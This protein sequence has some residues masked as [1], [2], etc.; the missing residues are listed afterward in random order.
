MK[1]ARELA[2]IVAS[3]KVN[4]DIYNGVSDH[5]LHAQRFTIAEHRFVLATIN[6]LNP[7][8]M[9]Y[10]NGIPQEG[11]TLPKWFSGFDDQFG[12]EH[13]PFSD[14]ARQKEREKIITN[15]LQTL[16]NEEDNIVLCIQECWEELYQNLVHGDGVFGSREPDKASFRAIVWTDGM[17]AQS[18]D[19]TQLRIFAETVLEITIYNVHLPFKTQDLFHQLNRMIRPASGK[20]F[21]VG[22]FNI[23]TQLISVKAHQEGSTHILQELVDELYH[24][25]ALFDEF[26]HP[27]YF[28]VHPNG[29]TNWNLRMNCADRENNRDHF[30]NIMLVCP[31]PRFFKVEPVV[32]NIT[33]D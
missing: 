7:N 5:V 13:R 6:V 23:P 19:P 22:D 14:P 24:L 18:I 8:Y 16:L 28:A 10:V 4:R 25:Q 30:D 32:W 15:S 26:R 3:T 33:M 1:T 12:L 21:V 31:D 20:A 11:K 17:Y 9:C 27:I 2:A 29:W